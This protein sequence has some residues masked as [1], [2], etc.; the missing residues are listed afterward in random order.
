MRIAELYKCALATSTQHQYS[1][2][3]K[4]WITFCAMWGWSP[5]EPSELHATQFV[6]WLSQTQQYRSIRN[7]MTGVKHYWA[8]MGATDMHLSTWHVYNQVLKG[9]R[10]G[11]SGVPMR[12]H[13]ISP[14]ELISMF[15]RF[16][17]TAFAHALKACILIAWWG[18]L[19]KSNVTADNINPSAGTHCI[20]R[21][22]VEVASAQYMLR[23]RVRSS[24]T[25]QFKERSV[26]LLLHGRKGHPLDPV[27]AWEKHIASSPLPATA[28]AF[29]F[30]EAGKQHHLQYD[31][32]RKALKMYFAEIGGSSV[33][34]SSHSLRRGG[35]TYAWHSGVRDIL[36]QAHG[37]WKSMCYR[38]YIEASVDARLSTTKRMFDRIVAGTPTVMHPALAPL[39]HVVPVAQQAPL[40]AIPIQPHA[41]SVGPADVSISESQDGVYSVDIVA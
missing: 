14:D 22:D 9:L 40:P 5:L 21:A 11:H 30:I 33:A 32:L 23:V 7:T 36:I 38:D 16:A 29:D 1:A 25:N 19:R 6:V 4:Y 26:E 37:D 18:M 28:H 12:K 15:T 8:Q 10:R 34:V 41:A 39:E 27:A 35:A 20:A 17:D 13:P 31:A 24:K 2:H 3:A